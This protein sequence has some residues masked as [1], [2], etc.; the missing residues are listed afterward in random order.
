MYLLF[1]DIFGI[2]FCF[3]NNV[4]YFDIIFVKILYY[5]INIFIIFYVYEYNEECMI[6]LYIV[7]LLYMK[8]VICR[9]YRVIVCLM[10]MLL[11]LVLCY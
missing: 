4:F 7:I 9:F 2:W 3:Y 1:N 5:C 10:E 11:M 6:M 8:F